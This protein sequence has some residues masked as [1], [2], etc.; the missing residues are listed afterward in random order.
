MRR[1]G[2]LGAMMRHHLDAVRDAGE[3]VS[4]LYAA[5]P[6]IYGRFG[7][8]LASQDVKLTVGRGA[9][10]RDVPGA[11]DVTVSFETVTSWTSPGTRTRWSHLRQSSPSAC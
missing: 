1:R 10:L 9:A 3:A 5:E 11:D 4:I 6:A 8:G 2:L 7:Y